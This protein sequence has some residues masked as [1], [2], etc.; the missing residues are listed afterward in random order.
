MRVHLL[1]AP[2]V[3][4]IWVVFDSTKIQLKSTMYVVTPFINCMSTIGARQNN[5]ANFAKA[6]RQRDTEPHVRMF[7]SAGFWVAKDRSDAFGES[8]QRNEYLGFLI[9]TA[10]MTSV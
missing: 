10:A 2:G 8:P 4:V 9:D 6:V 7:K 1:N 5:E 3:L